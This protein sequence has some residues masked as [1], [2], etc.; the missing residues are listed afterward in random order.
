MVH[1]A[2]HRARFSL[3]LASM[4]KSIPM[5]P[6]LP[7]NDHYCAKTSDPC[8]RGRAFWSDLAATR[9]RRLVSTFG[10]LTRSPECVTGNVKYG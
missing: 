7:R 6:V 5:G 2:C 10:S 8:R 3:L 4:A 9:A 1:L